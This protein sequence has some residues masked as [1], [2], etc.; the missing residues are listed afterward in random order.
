MYA[1]RRSEAAPSA[2]GLRGGSMSNVFWAFVAPPLNYLSVVANPFELG[3]LTVIPTMGA[4]ALA[5]G[6]IMGIR[7]RHGRLFLYIV[8]FAFSELLM[9]FFWLSGKGA[10]DDKEA[11]L[12]TFVLIQIVIAAYFIFLLRGVRGAAFALSLFSLIYA[13][14]SAIFASGLAGGG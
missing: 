6:V 14:F 12:I 3:W 8:P 2:I 7:A 9:A 10:I 11:L 5:A 13:L 1:N 4:V